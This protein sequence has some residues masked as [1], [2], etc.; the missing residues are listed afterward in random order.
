MWEHSKEEVKKQPWYE[1]VPSGLRGKEL[2]IWLSDW[3]IKNADPATDT[4]M[5][6]LY[7]KIKRNAMKLPD[8]HYTFTA[9]GQTYDVVCS[10]STKDG[11]YITHTIKN[12]ATGTEAIVAHDKIK[13]YILCAQP[14]QNLPSS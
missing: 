12:T 3:L 11:K 6:F 14:P 7:G 5:V 2:R 10:T 9:N 8:I 1:P 4:E 13:S